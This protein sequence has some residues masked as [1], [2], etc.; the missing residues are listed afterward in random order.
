MAKRP[1]GGSPS[2]CA[3]RARA[4]G[5]SGGLVPRGSDLQLPSRR[6]DRQQFQRSRRLPGVDAAVGRIRPTG[7][8]RHLDH[9]DRRCRR[10]SSARLLQVPR[11]P[12]HGRRLSGPG[13][14]GSSAGAQGVAGLRAARRI[15]PLSP[16]QRAPRV[17]R[18]RRRR[19]DAPLLVLRLQLAHLA[20]LHGRCGP[21][22]CEPV[23]RGRL[24]RRRR[25][26]QPDSQLEPLDSLR[27][28]SFAQLQG[29]LNM[30][31]SLRGARQDSNQSKAACWPKRRG[32]STA[33]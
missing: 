33:R 12:G 15:E 22:L 4:A 18:L 1:C 26:R 16:G 23:R 32:A 24:P 28:R 2:G 10:V 11:R 7:R 25:R 30:L 17:A 8:Q 20:G 31:R 27:P 3:P 13:G 21:V 14:Q 6:N 19:L 5:R 9:A 29:G